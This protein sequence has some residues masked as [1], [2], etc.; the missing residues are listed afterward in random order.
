MEILN[1]HKS[2]PVIAV[3]NTLIFPGL[4]VPLRVGRKKSVRAI[5]KAQD[6]GGWILCVL[7]SRDRGNEDVDTN[8]LYQVGTL[9]KVENLTGSAADGFQVLLRGQARV[10]INEYIDVGDHLSADLSEWPDEKPKEEAAEAEQ[11]SLVLLQSVKS[12]AKSLLDH[13]PVNSEQVAKVLDDI[14][15]LSFLIYLCAGYL[16]TSTV[17]KQELLEIPGTLERAER[18]LELLQKFKDQIDVQSEINQKLSRKLGRHQREAILREQLKAIREEL[19]EDED[20]TAVDDYEKRIEEAGM[21]EA[22][23][24]VALDE[25]KRLNKINSQ[26]PETQVIRNYLD[27]LVALPWNRGSDQEVDLE[28]ARKI[29]DEDHFGLEEIKKRILQHLAVMK[30]KKDKKGSILL[31]V[32]PPGVG[33]T[34]LG[35][36]IAKTLGRKFVRVSLGGVRDDA[37]IRGHRRTYVGAMPGR[38]I[39]GIRRAQENNPLFMLDEIDKM[40]RGFSGDPGGALLE[41]LDPEQNA[42]FV[43]HYLDVPFDLSKVTFIATANSLESI[44]GPLL[45]R[46]EVI[47]LSG[48]TTEEKLN[49]GKKYLLPKQREEHGLSEGQLS[50]PDDVLREIV[51]SY[52]REAGVRELERRIAGVCRWTA[53]RVLRNTANDLPILVRREDLD[54]MFGPPK[55]VYERIAEAS[56]AGV[57][58]GLA[59][60][61]QGGDILFIESSS[62]EGSG[63]LIL[64]GQ[65]GE[66]M[67]ESAQIALSVVRSW[68]DELKLK[69]RFDKLDL[70][71]HVPAGAIPK[72]GPSAG[73]A[74]LSSLAS[75]LTNIRVPSNLAMTGELT[76]RGAVM[77]VGGIKEKVLAAHR[78]GIRKIILP[79]KNERDL[80]DVPAEVQ[81]E[82]QFIFVQR[83]EEVVKAVLALNLG[84]VPIESSRSRAVGANFHVH[85]ASACERS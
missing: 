75:M 33:K 69:Q 9:C 10:R 8:D 46:M 30:L 5:Q 13:L 38:I 53:E 2:I 19:G 56:P 22:V 39:Q 84:G 50:V 47:Q 20:A 18:L 21:P 85:S 59:W 78:A 82:M 23:K 15:D 81:S 16:E 11:Q 68:A 34:S 40:M 77:P 37:E 25:L 70:H 67:K 6:E 83:A 58:T 48:Y 32:G 73:I 4:V 65:L 71:V 12:F 26:S 62:M 49:I 27:L 31:F 28:Q 24:K 61:P 44:P 42:S 43:D 52:T 80:R 64:T 74:M 36:S 55:F 29:L 63:K 7:Q 57:V 60:T 14:S 51:T 54:E 45:D 76:L 79:Q 41:V 3:R 17:S 72:D 35:Q 1:Y 66:V